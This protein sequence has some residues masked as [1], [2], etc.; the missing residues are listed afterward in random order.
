MPKP[1]ECVSGTYTGN[2]TQRTI[3]LGFK[4][5]FILLFNVTDGDTVGIHIDGMTDATSCSITDAVASAATSI[6]LIDTGFTLGISAVDNET[7]K[8]F[9]YVAIGGN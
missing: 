1:F 8:V 5:D 3:T 2:Q 9:R 4:P 7:G 6:T